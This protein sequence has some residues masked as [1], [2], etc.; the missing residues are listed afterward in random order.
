MQSTTT[1]RNPEELHLESL[2]EILSLD[3]R[4]RFLYLV[5]SDGSKLYHSGR[6]GVTSFD[7]EEQSDLINVQ[8]A[9]GTAMGKSS[10]ANNGKIRVISVARERLTMMVFPLYQAV[11]IVSAEADFPLGDAEKVYSALDRLLPDS[12]KDRSDTHQ[13][14]GMP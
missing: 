13:T 6:V 2:H 4:I 1:P 9:L 3:P 14:P 10:E 8:V 5:G 11:A 7:D 12:F